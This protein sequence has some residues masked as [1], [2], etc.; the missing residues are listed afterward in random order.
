ME[1]ERAQKAE[2]EAA[3]KK[4]LQEAQERRE[5]HWK[6]RDAR[7]KKKVDEAIA[8]ALHVI[9]ERKRAAQATKE[10]NQEFIKEL[11]KERQ[12][13]FKAQLERTVERER[14]REAEEQLLAAYEEKRLIPKKVKSKGK[15][16]VKKPKKEKDDK[17]GKT[18]GKKEKDKDKD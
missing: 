9:L 17:K 1:R 4:Q 13:F 18:K 10:R 11:H 12:P 2:E 5:Q 3:Y 7:V 8:K 6:A 16:A 14:E 15:N